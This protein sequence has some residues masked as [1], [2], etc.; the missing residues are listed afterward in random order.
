MP[1]V[2]SLSVVGEFQPCSDEFDGIDLQIAEG[3]L[4]KH[5]IA[6]NNKYYR[7]KTQVLES[8]CIDEDLQVWRDV[9]EL[10]FESK[11]WQYL[12]AGNK[13]R[14]ATQHAFF[15]S[16]LEAAPTKGRDGITQ[17]NLVK[18]FQSP[19]FQI[20]CMRRNT[21][22]HSVKLEVDRP[23]KKRPRHQTNKKAEQEQQQQQQIP[24]MVKTMSADSAALLTDGDGDGDD[25]TSD[26]ELEA[27]LGFRLSPNT[28]YFRAADTRSTSYR[29][30]AEE[31]LTTGESAATLDSSECAGYCSDSSFD[32]EAVVVVKTQAPST[33]QRRHSI[34]DDQDSKHT[35]TPDRSLRALSLSSWR[36][37]HMT[38]RS[39]PFSLGCAAIAGDDS[40]H[41]GLDA[42][43][44]AGRFAPPHSL[45]LSSSKDR[46]KSEIFAS[47][48]ESRFF[49]SSSDRDCEEPDSIEQY[50]A[51]SVAQQLWRNL[52]HAGSRAVSEE[53]VTA[54]AV[55]SARFED[56]EIILLPT[57]RCHQED[58][59]GVMSALQAQQ[60]AYKR[61]Q[62]MNRER[63]VE[64]RRETVVEAPCTPTKT[65]LTPA[66]AHIVSDVVERV[67]SSNS[68][69]AVHDFPLFPEETKPLAAL[70]TASAPVKKETW[71]PDARRREHEKLLRRLFPHMEGFK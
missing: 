17:L 66:A 58:Y 41:S 52:R 29:E 64:W 37:D 51:P 27:I 33:P 20:A 3:Y 4:L 46:S 71:S 42:L 67:S 5:S 48:T 36:H 40:S 69:G 45:S 2:E 28:A 11:P 50:E 10:R 12:W 62:H 61:A 9:I 7:A 65:R 59:A 15:V 63:P 32:D 38:T 57:K 35:V 39:S 21:A 44:G 54:K 26:C 24:P 16:I 18:Q 23:V 14:Q 6:P 55:E 19:T 60:R 25:E 68:S 8:V 31:C 1:S 13:V 34:G 22:A 30:P 70:G 53:S 43:L 49:D 47:S 56:D